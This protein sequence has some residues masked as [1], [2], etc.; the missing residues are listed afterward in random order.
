MVKLNFKRNEYGSYVAET[1]KL[2]ISIEKDTISGI[3]KFKPGWAI[4][5]LNKE[6]KNRYRYEAETLK[7]AKHEAGWLVEGFNTRGMY[8]N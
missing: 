7:E 1:T 4:N 2:H 8:F 3:P 5:V 6:T